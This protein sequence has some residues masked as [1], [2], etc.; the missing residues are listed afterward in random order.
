M[1]IAHFSDC[2]TPRI[3]GVTT[4]IQVLKRALEREGHEVHLFVPR[5]QRQD[6]P[7]KAVHRIGSVYMPLQP[8]DRMGLPWPPGQMRRLYAQ[9]F[10]IVHVHTPFN[11]GWMGYSKAFWGGTPMVFTHHTLWEEYAHYLKI[12]PLR[13]GRWVGRQLCDFYFRRARAV[14]MPSH[15]V[16]EAIKG[17]LRCRYEV[18]PTGIDCQALHH[19]DA[20]AARQELRLNEG[21]A[22]FLYVGR[23]GKE[24]SIDYL[25]K[26]F[27]DYRQAG[28]QAH[29]AL[30]GGGPELE[31]LQRM[32]VE[33]GIGPS[34]HFLGYRQRD[35]LKDYLAATKI[36]LFASQT[37]T[38]GL[39][40]LEAAAAGVPVIAVRASGV[41][42]AVEP[43]GSGLLTAP[44]HLEEFVAAIR[45]LDGD[46]AL[47][48]RLSQQASRWAERFSDLEMGRKMTNLYR[49]LGH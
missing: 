42:E 35:R 3:N 21:D 5:Y 23:M 33:M 36:F 20:R 10:D 34:C 47:H 19:G 4:S 25:L 30:I 43:E 14:V 16:A 27:R 24:K 15:E 2:Y 49:S 11:M 44:G 28:G 6:P 38:Q 45:R 18:I 39:V 17:R 46:P 41:N 8:E 26:A 9:K 13:L 40:L 29:F 7:E 32:T 37:E 1:R 31:N 48:Q 22:L 12:V